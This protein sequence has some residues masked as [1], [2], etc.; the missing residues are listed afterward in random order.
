MGRPETGAMR[1][2]GD[3]RGVFIRGDN[4]AG[5][6]SY[7]RMAQHDPRY[8]RMLNGLIALLES[9]FEGNE[10]VNIQQMKSYDECTANAD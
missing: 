10:G 9:A 3:W 2:E 6:L 5:Y 7:L 1:F 4:A 8:L